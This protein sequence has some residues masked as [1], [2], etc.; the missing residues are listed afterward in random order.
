[1]TGS[2]SS[3]PR[4]IFKAKIPK[5]PYKIVVVMSDELEAEEM[6]FVKKLEELRNLTLHSDGLVSGRDFREVILRQM[7]LNYGLFHRQHHDV[8]KLEEGIA[9]FTASAERL[10]KLTYALIGLTLLLGGLSIY[11][12]FIR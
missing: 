6:A 4:H 5:I 8:K 7:E 11:D 10:E 1:M 3:L 2:S 12:L 9:R